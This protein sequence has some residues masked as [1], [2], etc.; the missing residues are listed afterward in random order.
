MI[1]L[2]LNRNCPQQALKE[3]IRESKQW[4]AFLRKLRFISLLYEGKGVREASAVLGV[5]QACGY[6]WLGHWNRA[7]PIGFIPKR[8][9]GRPSKFNLED[10]SREIQK[11]YEL[12]PSG[13]EKLLLEKYGLE[14]SKRNLKR[15]HA[16]LV[17]GTISKRKNSLEVYLLYMFGK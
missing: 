10:L 9:S 13:L 3:L 8:K 15:I 16:K 11:Q 14:Y 12:L 2:K 5:T 1:V 7:G 17:N 6:L 4:G